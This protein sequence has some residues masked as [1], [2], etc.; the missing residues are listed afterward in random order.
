M[1]TTE[2]GK[3]PWLIFFLEDDKPPT[4]VP[5]AE[6]AEDATR[7]VVPRGSARGW[8]LSQ[9]VGA[10]RRLLP[11]G[12]RRLSTAPPRWIVDL[13]ADI[14]EVYWIVQ[15]VLY[16]RVTPKATE[17]IRAVAARATTCRLKGG[18]YRVERIGML[19]EVQSEE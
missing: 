19:E 3:G 7:R 10:A 12:P 1:D 18:I 11:A 13:F 2:L 15:P 8:L 14:P 6:R 4:A 16:V 9:L 17:S 5:V